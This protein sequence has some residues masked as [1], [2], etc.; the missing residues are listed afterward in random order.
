MGLSDPQHTKLWH[1]DY[2]G[3]EL[4]LQFIWDRGKLIWPA[5]TE[6]GRSKWSRHE[7]YAG[8]CEVTRGGCDFAKTRSGPNCFRL[9]T[10]EARV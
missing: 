6:I 7:H 2:H 10:L 1:E 8:F 4:E 5:V 3:A 9:A